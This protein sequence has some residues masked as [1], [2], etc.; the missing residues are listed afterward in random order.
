MLRNRVV[1]EDYL[2]GNFEIRWKFLQ[3]ILFNQNVYLAVNT[4]LDFGMVTG[5]YDFNRADIP[6]GYEY[7]FPDTKE[8]LHLTYGAGFHIA[9][10]EN[11]IIAIN[12]GFAT[13]KQDGTSG[14]YIGLKW[15][16]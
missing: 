13:D 7:L 15:L 16:F 3:T 9:I 2:Y 12:N 1:G 4:F 8:K 14:L 11:F 6:A 5:K 10:N